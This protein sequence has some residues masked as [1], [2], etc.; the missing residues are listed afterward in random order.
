MNNTQTHTEE[1]VQTIGSQNGE[2][3]RTLVVV[4]GREAVSYDIGAGTT[5]AEVAEAVGVADPGSVP[6]YNGVNDA[7]SPG[8][9]IDGQTE[10]V[11]FAFK[12]AGA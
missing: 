5:L 10:V 1:V 12:L 2:L 3:A 11:N 6:A 8:D 4:P 9:V 7:L